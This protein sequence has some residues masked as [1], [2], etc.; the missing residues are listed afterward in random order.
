[1]IRSSATR[2]VG[3]SREGA[4]LTLGAPVLEPKVEFSMSVDRHWLSDWV[5]YPF[6]LCYSYA[7][8]QGI[9]LRITGT[10]QMYL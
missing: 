4:W 6:L 8:S 9:L 7:F 10:S 3:L 2:T 5:Y 1:M